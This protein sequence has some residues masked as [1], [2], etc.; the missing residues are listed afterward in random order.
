MI[1][2]AKGAHI[3]FYG[4]DGHAECA[5]SGCNHDHFIKADRL[6]NFEAT[7]SETDSDHV[8]DVH[9][10]VLAGMVNNLNEKRLQKKRFGRLREQTMK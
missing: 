9:Y 10:G 3:D 6:K 4:E 5:V 7:D 1:L 8:E 2:A